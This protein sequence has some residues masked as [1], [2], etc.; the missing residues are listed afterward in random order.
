MGGMKVTNVKNKV[1]AIG[2]NLFESGVINIAS[3][4]TVT[5]GT[6]LKRLE[7]GK[8]AP[9][10]STETI[11]GTH[12]VPASGGGWSTEPTDPVPGDI[13]TAVMP[14]DLENLG[15]APADFGF[16]AIVSGRVRADMLTINGQAPTAEQND[17]LRSY[18]SVP[19]KVTDLSQL[20]N[21]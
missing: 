16:R 9:V 20:D 7:N 21:Q 18:G 5:A 11:P 13:P 3:N 2:D 10:V 8:F 6:V 12:G 19:V 15:S 4:T 14:W 1:V 17:L